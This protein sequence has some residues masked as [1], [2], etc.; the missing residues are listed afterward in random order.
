MKLTVRIALLLITCRRC[1]SST[2][3]RPYGPTLSLLRLQRLRVVQA[4]RQDHQR[5]A[6]HLV[7]LSPG[8]HGLSG[9]DSTPARAARR[10]RPLAGHR[11]HLM[12]RP[13]PLLRQQLLKA[14]L[15]EATAAGLRT[16]RHTTH[17]SHVKRATLMSPTARQ[18][19]NPSTAA[20]EGGKRRTGIA[21]AE[22]NPSVVLQ[23][24]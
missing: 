20:R 1:T 16:A 3:P 9:H 10:V 18:I 8:Q 23:C 14:L 2:P 6:S 13:Q 17:P 5:A 11:H 12:L 21:P 24:Y 22:R 4:L 19:C 15:R 7:F